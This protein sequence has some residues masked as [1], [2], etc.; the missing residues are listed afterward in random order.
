MLIYPAYLQ[1]EDRRPRDASGFLDIPILKSA[2][3][4][5]LVRAEDDT[6]GV[7]NSLG[8]YLA[9]V[10]EKIRAEMHLYA[11]G[12]H[13]YGLRP[14]EAEVTHWTTPATS[15]LKKLEFVKSGTP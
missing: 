15:W 14:T 9:L 6:A 7:G 3:P 8:E 1:E 10:K 11:V 4:T 12:G 5:F 13:G 2:P